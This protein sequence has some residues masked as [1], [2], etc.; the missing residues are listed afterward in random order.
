[1]AGKTDQFIPIRITALKPDPTN[2]RS[3]LGTED[4]LRLLGQSLMKH[5]DNPLIVLKDGTVID[6]NRRLKAA[7]LVGLETLDCIVREGEMT[8]TEIKTLQLVSV[9]H[10]ADISAW[11]KA[12]AAKMIKEGA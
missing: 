10:R 12:V 11:D 1:M 7:E 8:A 3:G 6:G 5:Q 2:I 9:V 4:Q